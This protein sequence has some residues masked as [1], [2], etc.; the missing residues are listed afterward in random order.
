LSNDFSSTPSACSKTGSRV[1]GRQGRPLEPACRRI[2]KTYLQIHLQGRWGER[3]LPAV[4]QGPA[5]ATRHIPPAVEAGPA[6]PAAPARAHVERKYACLHTLSLIAS[7]C[8]GLDQEIAFEEIDTAGSS[9]LAV[10]DPRRT[11]DQTPV[12]AFGWRVRGRRGT[13]HPPQRTSR[14]E[15]PWPSI[16]QACCAR[17]SCFPQAQAAA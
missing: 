8:R 15:R 7:H 11:Q 2:T 10:R 12:R 6:K 14:H 17:R 3:T 9:S 1:L 13:A 5:S 16:G 4:D